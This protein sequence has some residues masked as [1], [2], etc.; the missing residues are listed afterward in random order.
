MAEQ[1]VEHGGRVV[2]RAGKGRVGGGGDDL[3]KGAGGGEDEDDLR[4]SSSGSTSS[5]SG[6]SVSG[7]S[8]PVAEKPRVVEE[9]VP[10]AI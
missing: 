5:W 10:G 6:S 4:S 2:A 7:G 9:G 8:G 3:G 1:R